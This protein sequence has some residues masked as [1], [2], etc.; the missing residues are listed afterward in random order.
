MNRLVRPFPSNQDFLELHC[1]EAAFHAVNA[2]VKE[3]RKNQVELDSSVLA[4]PY[5]IELKGAKP[6][7]GLTPSFV[8]TFVAQQINC[9][10]SQKT[11]E[12]V[13]G[14]IDD[15]RNVYYAI[16]ITR[17]PLFG[18]YI[19]CFF[20]TVVWLVGIGDGVI[21]GIKTGFVH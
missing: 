14:K 5:E 6:G 15:I 8:Y 19:E 2:S 11:G 1:G 13:E 18:C 9:L 16:A 17:H 7:D 20:R 12:V 10:R 3:R 4:G 21:L